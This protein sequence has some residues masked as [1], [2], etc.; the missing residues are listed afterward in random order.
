MKL[1]IKPLLLS[2]AALALMFGV[3]DNAQAVLITGVTASSD[4][5]N[6]TYP[7]FSTPNLIN[8]VNGRGL[9]GN[10]PSLT[11]N[12]RAATLSNNAWLSQ[13]GTTTGNITFNLNSTYDLN[14]F[15]FWNWNAANSLRGIKDVTV[16][17]STNG[18]IFT[19]L[20]TTQ[21]AQGPSGAES[22]E[23]FS[24]GPVTASFVRF[25]VGS[26]YFGSGVTGF[27]EA[28]FSAVPWET[29]ALPVVGSTLLF[30]LGVWGKRRLANRNN[31]PKSF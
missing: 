14:G 13:E 28:Q 20:F 4:M 9:L 10:T 30:G 19:D 5:G 18:F 6:L 3:A 15:S 21:F 16:Q 29:D 17:T 1:S 12:H 11:G 8:T 2:S 27:S 31:T 25:Q 26:H 24:F 22:P 7:G 23:Q